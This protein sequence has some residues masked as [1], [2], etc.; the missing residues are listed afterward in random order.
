MKTKAFFY[1]L[2]ACVV[3]LIVAVLGVYT[4]ST[5]HSNYKRAERNMEALADS[6]QFYKTSDGKNAAK[7]TELE[8]TKGEYEKLMKSQSEEIKRLGIKIKQLQSTSQTG[9]STHIDTGDVPLHDTIYIDTTTHQPVSAKVFGWSDA[10]TTIDG[11]IKE[12]KVVQCQYSSRDTLL[13]AVYRVPH[14]FLFFRW[15]TK[16]IEQTVVSSNPHTIIT[17]DAAIRFKGRKK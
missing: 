5:E 13:T 4:C 14:K 1:L 15:G 11:L 6:S 8:L 9:T 7:I 3:L 17:Y 2:A 12:D 10:W 16:Y